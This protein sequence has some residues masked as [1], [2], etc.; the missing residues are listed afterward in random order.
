MRER[1]VRVY[2][3]SMRLS[4][5]RYRTYGAATLAGLL[6]NVFFGVLRS[7]VFI[8]L[9]QNR[10][11]TDGFS[12]HDAVSY[13][14]LSQGMIMPIY[15]WGWFEIA[16]TI[17][18]GDVV[19]DFA[20]PFDY[21]GYWLSRDLG[22]AAYHVIYRFVP[23]VVLGALLF[24]L[25]LPRDPL[26]WPLFGLSLLLAIVISFCLRFA[27]N[28]S[29]FWTVDARGLYSVLFLFVNFLSGFLVPLA[30][31]PPALATIANALPFAGMISIPLTIFLEQAHGLTLVR[32]LLEQALWA[33]VFVVAARLVLR[34]AV[35]KLVVQGG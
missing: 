20:K 29:A 4:Y 26:T 33:V 9:Y 3:E 1:M 5:R 12:L 25:R 34:A 28:V 32:L 6:T 35:R 22:R 18:S 2:L 24:G 16:N 7:Y 17:R 23:T 19:T 21:F 10:S 31:F 14:W 8:A 11:V 27:L 15:L 13:V 30:F